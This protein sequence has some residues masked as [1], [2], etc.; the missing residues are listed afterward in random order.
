MKNLNK[1]D[2]EYLIKLL[3]D[4]KDFPLDYKYKLFPTKQKEYELAYEGKMRKEDLIA[5]E[6]GVFP[7]PLQVEKVFNGDEYKMFDDD[8]KN[9]IVF[10]DNLQFLKTVY[11]NKDPLIKNKVKGKVKLI[12]IDPPFATADEFK[13]KEGAKAYTDKKKGAEFVE[14]LRR[15]LILAREILADDGCIFVHLDQKMSH[16]IKILM[17]EV[18]GKQSFVNEIIWGYR[19][20]GVGKKFWARKHDTIFYYRKSGNYTFYPEKEKNIYENPFIDTKVQKSIIEKLKEKDR[21]IIT[22]NLD[23]NNSIPYRYKKYLFDTYYSEV[24]VRDVWDC[25]YTKPLISGSAEY[26]N[27][28]TQKPEGLFARI[29]KSTTNKNDIVLDFFGGSGSTMAVAEK[30]GR[31][32]ITCDLGKLSHYTM[33]KRILQIQDSKDLENLKEKYGKKAKSF[34]TAQ[35]GMYD[36]KKALDLEW[37]KYQ[38]FVSGLFEVEVKKN[39]ISGF[40]FD[41]KKGDYPVKIFDYRKFKDSSINESYLKEMHSVVGKKA[42]GRVYIIS[43]ANF[44]DF[45]TNYHDIDGIKYYF[46]KIPYHVIKEL[47]KMPFQKLRQPQSKKKVNDLD[48]AVGFHFIRHPE[49]K[50][51]LKKNKNGLKILIKSFISHELESDKTQDEKGMKNFETLSAVFVDKN[52]NGKAFEMDEA[53]FADELLPKKSKKSDDENIKKELK[54]LQKKGLEINLKKSELGKQI[55][56][57]YTDIYGND[58]TETFDI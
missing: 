36:L 32:W 30:L 12:Y 53:F 44:V 19:I 2:K 16:Y 29:I 9:M 8:W 55:M 43:P 34:V 31:K 24:Y 39:I 4:E 56:V 23:N 11:E 20:Q 37:K 5:N 18:F 49:V 25:D 7:V 17:D 48:E 40:E 26:F 46:L 3:K 54:K 45:L 28:P 47:H 33:Q 38:E 27:Y 14:F 52:Y 22:E 10:G 57:I 1:Y 50:S 41:G 58:F 35:L 51:Q 6:D 15:R 21:K 13:N 42:S